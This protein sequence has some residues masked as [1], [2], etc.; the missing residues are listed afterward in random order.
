MLVSTKMVLAIGPPMVARA[1]AFQTVA[2]MLSLNRISGNR[3]STVVSAVIRMGR[4]RSS[5]SLDDRRLQR[6]APGIQPRLHDAVADTLITSVSR[7]SG[8]GPSQPG[9]DDFGQDRR[10]PVRF[11]TA[12]YI[13]RRG[14]R[15]LPG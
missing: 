15:C 2:S 11:S 9:Q 6:C 7:S 4:T 10:V 13:R 5:V 1:S 12:T 3:P 8:R 14:L